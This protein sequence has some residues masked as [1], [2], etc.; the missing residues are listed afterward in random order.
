MK[1]IRSKFPVFKS[2]PW[3][4]L[5]DSWATAQ[6]P[7]VVIDAEK[8][9]NETS[10]WA[11]GRW[12]CSLSL[13]ATNNYENAKQEIAWFIW[14]KSENISLVWWATEWLNIIANWIKHN[15]KAWDEILISSLEHNS[16]VLPWYKLKEEIWIKIVFVE[17][18]KNQEITL[19]DIKKCISKKTKVISLTHVSNVS[20]QILPVEEVWS[21]AKEKNILFFVDWCQAA[22]HIKVDVN[23]IQAS[24]YVFSA[25][26]LWWPT[27]IWCMYLN[28]EL[29]KEIKSHN[30]WGWIVVKVTKD[31]YNLL[32][33][34]EKHEAGTQLLSQSIW[35][36]AACKFLEEYW[37]DNLR[38][39]EEE[40]LHYARAELEKLEWLVII[41]PKDNSKRSW[42]ISFHFSQVHTHDIWCILSD[43]NICVRSWLHC[44][45]IAHQELWISWTTR[46]SF[47]LYNEK[48]EIDALVKVLSEVVKTFS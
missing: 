17:L 12:N 10:Y 26:K 14:A 48:K 36:A 43:N 21:I 20:G 29:V 9:F 13:E 38:K 7:W 24:W 28:D 23:K 40:L 2:H 5:F 44:A 8:I 18:N 3:I 33:W 30:L 22:P 11:V 46:L 32:E 1:D 41:W 16:N 6:K 39:K 19:E 34:M 4:I 27:W 35:F 37:Y 45:D 42:I 25:H 15:L 47:W 31:S